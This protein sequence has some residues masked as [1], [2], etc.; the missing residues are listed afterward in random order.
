MEKIHF[1]FN[2]KLV[3]AEE[4]ETLFFTRISNLHECIMDA[5]VDVKYAKTR[6]RKKRTKRGN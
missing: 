1:E 5:T 2:L 4:L 6:E 3:Q